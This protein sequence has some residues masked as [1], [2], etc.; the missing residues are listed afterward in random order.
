MREKQEAATEAVISIM[1]IEMTIIMIIIIIIIYDSFHLI[2]PYSTSLYVCIRAS[3]APSE[4]WRK[5]KGVKNF[6]EKAIRERNDH[7]RESWR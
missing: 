6:E 1:M 7:R 2:T 3:M 4:Q 5:A